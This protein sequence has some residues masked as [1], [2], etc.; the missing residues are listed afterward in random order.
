MCRGFYWVRLAD[1][2]VINV[3]YASQNGV[4][5]RVTLVTMS[6]DFTDGDFI[7]TLNT[8]FPFE[9][10]LPGVRYA[11]PGTRLSKRLYPDS[12]PRPGSELVDRVDEAA[13][14]H[15]IQYEMY[16][17]RRQR[18]DADKA[19]INELINI[20]KPTCRERIER[21]FVLPIMVVKRCITA[22]FLRIPIINR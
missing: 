18:L 6:R 5:K 15:D 1:I 9:K 4:V 7:E 12:T 16:Q 2:N 21:F 14:R 17:D 11:G 8:C 10:H 19:M 3:G 22:C 20:E 13:M